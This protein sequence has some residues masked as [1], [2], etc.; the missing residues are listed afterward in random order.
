MLDL[1]NSGKFCPVSNHSSHD[2]VKHN[3]SEANYMNTS[4]RH[5]SIRIKD[6]LRKIHISFL[7]V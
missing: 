6:V 1:D 3:Y 2:V 5:V 4:F 7:N